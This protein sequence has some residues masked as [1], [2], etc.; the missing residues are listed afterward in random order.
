MPAAVCRLLSDPIYLILLLGTGVEVYMFGF[1]AFLPK[2][3]S[4]QFGISASMASILVG[5]H[6]RNLRDHI[7]CTTCISEMIP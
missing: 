1:T 6:I 7:R 5:K 2:Y 4:L 3:L